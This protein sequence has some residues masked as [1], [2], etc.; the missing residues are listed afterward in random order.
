MESMKDKK[1]KNLLLVLGFMKAADEV[2]KMR[3][4]IRITWLTRDRL[5]NFIVAMESEAC[6]SKLYTAGIG[7]VMRELLWDNSES[8]GSR[9]ARKKVP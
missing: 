4:A 9:G 2:K 1:R 5:L 7:C 6:D 8:L 3:S